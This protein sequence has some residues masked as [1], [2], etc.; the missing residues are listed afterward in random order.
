MGARFKG[1]VSLSTVASRTELLFIAID[2]FVFPTN[3]INNDFLNFKWGIISKSSFVSPLF[4]I[5]IHTSSEP[6]IPRSPCSA[7]NGFK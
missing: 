2:E 3:A 5:K 4:D 7:S 6:T 1:H